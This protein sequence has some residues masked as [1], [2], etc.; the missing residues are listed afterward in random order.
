MLKKYVVIGI[1]L[2]ICSLFPLQIYAG[3]ANGMMRTEQ[4]TPSIQVEGNSLTISQ[5]DGMT[6]EIYT[7]TGSKTASYVIEGNQVRIRTN[8]QKGWYILKLGT[9]VRKIAI[10]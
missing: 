1:V 5:A 4:V 2:G 6:L 8:L 9:I 10:K 7:L 3:E